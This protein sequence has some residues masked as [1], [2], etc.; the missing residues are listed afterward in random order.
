[1]KIALITGTAYRH[2]YYANKIIETGNV[3]LHIK[4]TRSNVLTDEIPEHAYQE[5]DLQLLKKH[6]D[7]RLQKEQEYF[8]PFAQEILPTPRSVE[9]SKENLHSQ[10]VID[11][12]SESKPDIVLVYGPGLLKAPLLRVTPKW[13]INLHAGLSPSFRGAATLFWPIYFMKPQ[14][15]GYTFHIIDDQID[16]GAIIHQNRPP[17][18]ASD[19]IHDLGCKTIITA[20]NDMLWLLPKIEKNTIELYEPKSSG[21][22]FFESEFK[23]YH[24][25]VTDFLM[26]HGLLGEYLDHK[27]LFPEPMTIVTQTNN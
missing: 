2:V 12:L 1:M 24:L 11:A 21:K 13:V 16:H 8:L 22:T 3:I 6:S 7:L 15:V 14:F 5:S 18:L 17:I 23:P 4:E 10:E 26:K 9:V 25:R 27:E 20:T 19:T